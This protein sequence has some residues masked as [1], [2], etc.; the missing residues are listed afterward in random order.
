LRAPLATPVPSAV[1]LG[2]GNPVTAFP[3]TQ[4]LHAAFVSI[5]AIPAYLLCRRLVLPQWLALAVAALAVAVPDGVY[6]SSMLADPLA[7][8]LVLAAVYTGVSLVT[9]STPRRQLA[10]AVFA[11]LAVSARIQ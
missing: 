1:W 8:P 3:V 7:Y 10:F 5:A 2:T 4:A 6:A 9:E 11:A